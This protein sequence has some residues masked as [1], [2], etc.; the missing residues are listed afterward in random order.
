MGFNA[1][2]YLGDCENSVAFRLFVPG[3]IL[4]VNRSMSTE[5]LRAPCD[6]F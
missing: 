6:S 1:G 4:R 5:R 2:K 3:L